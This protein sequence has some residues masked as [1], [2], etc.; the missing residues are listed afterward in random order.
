MAGQS[1]SPSGMRAVTSTRPYL[2]EA[3]RRVL[4]RAERTGG[5]MELL[6]AVVLVAATQFSKRVDV[7]S[8]EERRSIL[9]SERRSL[10]SCRVALMTSLPSST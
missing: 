7:Q 10:S 6:P 3:P 5:T 2:I 8:P 9:E 4:R 1:Q